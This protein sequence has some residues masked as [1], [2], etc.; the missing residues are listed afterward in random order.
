MHLFDL[1]ISVQLWAIIPVF[2]LIPLLLR[3]FYCNELCMDFQWLLVI[4]F[5]ASF[6]LQ[7]ITT[8]KTQFMRRET[9]NQDWCMNKVQYHVHVYDTSRNYWVFFGSFSALLNLHY[10]HSFR[11]G[12]YCR[13]TKSQYIC[14]LLM[15]KTESFLSSQAIK[16]PLVNKYDTK[17]KLFC[18]FG[19]SKLAS[20]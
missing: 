12:N 11:E 17:K 7:I 1:G 18:C 3:K 2:V 9:H 19:E 15:L 8:N 14:F 13:K 4:S 20:Q 5:Y 6:I 16:R 10:N